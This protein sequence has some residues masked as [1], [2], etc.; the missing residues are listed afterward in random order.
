MQDQH[1]S[2][3]QSDAER[4]V[5]VVRQKDAELAALRDQA[6]A[7]ERTEQALAKRDQ[8]LAQL[9]TQ[10]AMVPTLQAQVK[11]QTKTIETMS[12]STAKN[13][14]LQSRIAELE[15]QAYGHN[16][17][18]SSLRDE[19]TRGEAVVCVISLSVSL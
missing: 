9:R 16:A 4:L 2:E 3:A 12:S 17:E 8:E 7:T 15:A 6:D 18:I 19:I 11:A 14:S 1:F 13:A 5:S 10:A